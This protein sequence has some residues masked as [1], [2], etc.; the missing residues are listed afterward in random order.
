MGLYNPLDWYWRVNGDQ[1]KVYG[2]L[3]G[4]YAATA[5]ATYQ[6]WLAAGNLPTTI[7]SEAS[8][9]AVLAPFYPT[10]T[11]PVPA[12]ILDGYQQSQSD[13]VFQH[14]VIKLLFVLVNRIQVLEGKAPFTVAQAR[15]YVKGLM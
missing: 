4:D 8:L 7:E 14:K 3:R 11:R 10:V 13:D 6:A 5:D 2:S 9:G 12:V 15:A 1:T